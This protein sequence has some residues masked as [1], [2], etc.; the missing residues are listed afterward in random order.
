[1]SNK[2]LEEMV[3][4]IK[5][6]TGVYLTAEQLEKL[7]IFGTNILNNCIECFNKVEGGDNFEGTFSIPGINFQ[8][9]LLSSRGPVDSI[10]DDSCVKSTLLF[11]NYYSLIE[12]NDQ[13]TVVEEECSEV[14]KEIC[15]IR[16]G[17]NRKEE[18]IE[19]LCDVIASGL[20]CIKQLGGSIEQADNIIKQ[21]YKRVIDRLDAGQIP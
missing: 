3:T 11:E 13:L 4:D 9:S 16:R 15:K 19:E 6:G 18:L 1:M 21:K 2:S 20:S 5:S 12:G 10:D 17:H 14:I 8:V 7:G